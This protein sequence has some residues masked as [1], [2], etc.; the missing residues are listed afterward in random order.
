MTKAEQQVLDHVDGKSKIKGHN[1]W[2]AKAVAKFIAENVL[3]HDLNGKLQRVIKP[4]PLAFTKIELG[5]ITNALRSWALKAGAQEEFEY[6]WKLLGK[7]T[8]MLMQ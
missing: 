8:Q 2:H 7:A 3:T 6:R 4:E 5:N 1:R